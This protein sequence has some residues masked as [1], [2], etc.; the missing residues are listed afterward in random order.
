MKKTI[1][2]VLC[3]VAVAT[4]QAQINIGK[5]ASAATKGVQALSF[6]NEDAQK[7]SKESVEWMDAHNIKWRM[8]KV[9]ILSDLTV[10]LAST[11]T[12]TA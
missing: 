2:T 3:M 10:S 8:Q 12:K 11:K 9:L 1:L 6:S 4:A 5:M 7:L